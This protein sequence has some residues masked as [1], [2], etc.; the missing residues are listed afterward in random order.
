MTRKKAFENISQANHLLN[1]VLT[2]ADD[3]TEQE[4][5]EITAA[6]NMLERLVYRTQDHRTVIP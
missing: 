5:A 4:R 2:W 3:F 1:H 6:S